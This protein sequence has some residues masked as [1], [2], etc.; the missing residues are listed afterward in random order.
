MQVDFG[1]TASDYARHRA[2]FPEAFFE[3]LVREGVVRPGLRAMD[4]GTGTG[5][6]ARG[7]ARRGCQVTAVDP[8]TPLLEAGQRLAAEEGLS[9]EWREGKAED[10]GLP[11]GEWDLVVAGQCWHWFDRPA[12][13]REA[14]RLLRPGGRLVRCHFDWVPA[15]GNVVEATDALVEQF[16]PTPVAWQ[17]FGHNVGVY[18]E[19]YR[20]ATHAGFVSLEG[21]TF[22][23]AVPYSHEDWRGRIRASAKVGAALAPEAVARFDEALAALLAERFPHQLQVPHRVFCLSA[24]RPAA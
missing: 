16:N 9:V 24:T 3:R 23:V 15:P 10:T 1:K 5:T 11:S 18:P 7:L 8:A 14:L 2:G 13:A 21:F 22:D 19:W 12:A 4:V 20:D 6:I 17:R